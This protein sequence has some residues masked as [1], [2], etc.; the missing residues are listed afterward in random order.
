MQ[1]MSISKAM[2]VEGMQMSKR[3]FTAAVAMEIV[4]NYLSSLALHR[5]EQ[6]LGLAGEALTKWCGFL[7]GSHD[8][9]KVCPAF[10]FQVDEVGKALAKT[11]Y[12][13]LHIAYQESQS[14]TR[15]APHG[16]VTARTLPNY[17]TE[18]GIEVR[19]AKRLAAI[20]GG[21]HGFFLQTL[22]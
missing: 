1:Y 11:G 16:I 14:K 19:L 5:L 3:H 2:P 8:L 21:H 12:Y 9:G 15:N 4:N 17:L 7:A 10:Q 6:G 20:V 18:F 22:K 13:N